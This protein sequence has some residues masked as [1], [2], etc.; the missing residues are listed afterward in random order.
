MLTRACLIPEF[1]L[2]T[3]TVSGLQRGSNNLLQGRVSK[4]LV[5]QQVPKGPPGDLW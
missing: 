2:L 5:D 3:F 4:L 1:V